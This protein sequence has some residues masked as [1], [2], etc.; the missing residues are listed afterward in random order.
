MSTTTAVSR[1]ARVAA[2]DDRIG[3][4]PLEKSFHWLTVLLVLA[5]YGLSQAWG[6]VPRGPGRHGLILWHISLG[7]LLTAVV[8]LRILWRA[9]PGRRVLPASTG[10]VERAAQGMHYLLYVLLLAQI[11]LGFLFRWS[12]NVAV[13]FFGLFDIPPV[14]SFSKQ[15]HH[16]VAQLHNWTAY[17]ILG[18]AG[19][20]AAAALVHHFVL[21]DDV[22]VRMLPG[23]RAR[24]APDPRRLEQSAD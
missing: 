6:W 9:G 18:F 23:R 16:L 5:L 19:L 8:V 7:V 20:H 1:A 2:G 10:W 21:R 24:S 11:V 15:Q 14:T 12:D 22:L 3:Y 4:D 13:S 17:L